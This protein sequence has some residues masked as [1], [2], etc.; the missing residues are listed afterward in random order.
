MNW[1][2]RALGVGIVVVTL[3]LTGCGRNRTAFTMAG[4]TAFQPFA[5]KLADQYM[6]AHPD[7]AITVE[8]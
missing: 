2:W 7:V 4:S 1:F 6:V 5:E 3:G 8:K